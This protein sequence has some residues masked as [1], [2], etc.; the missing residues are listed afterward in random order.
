[1]ANLTIA[2]R[3]RLTALAPAAMQTASPGGGLTVTS[4]DA[5]PLREPGTGRRYTVLRVKAQG[6]ATGFGEC[7]G[8]TAAQLDQ[9]RGIVVGQPATAYEVLERRLA[10]TPTAQCGVVMALLDLCGKAAKAPVYQ[11]LGG[12]TRFKA[13]ALATLTGG[14]NRELAERLA[15][16]RAGGYQAFSVPLPS[17]KTFSP[18]HGKDFITAV[19]ERMAALREA[20]GDTGDL[21]LDGAGGMTTGDASAVAAA[22]ERFHPLWLNEPC[23]VA[24]LGAVRKIAQESVTP[25]GFGAGIAD[26]AMF[27]NLLREECADLLRPDLSLM[28]IA[29]ARRVAAMA[30]TY[31]VAVA[32]RLDGGPI[33][34]AAALQ[35]AA[36]L[37]N[38]FIQE[39][40]AASGEARAMRNALAGAIEQVTGGFLALPTGPGLGVR[41]DES[42][43]T[44]YRESA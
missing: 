7:S 3:A 31:Y 9:T 44:K 35:L 28:S 41:V 11:V 43:L 26:A 27:Q 38:F 18:N 10:G 14:T 12:P 4:I 32:P 13:R 25:L 20:A 24:N 8:L 15:E 19:E 39:V 34:T 42:V 33:A 6:G 5:Y 30:E 23:A 1:M 40:P 37:P 16:A 29:R 2:R 21:V 17:I 22:V 36:A